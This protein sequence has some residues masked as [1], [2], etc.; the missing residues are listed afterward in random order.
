MNQRLVIPS[1][2]ERQRQRRLAY[3]F[4][5]GLRL[6][7]EIVARQ[8]DVEDGTDFRALLIEAYKKRKRHD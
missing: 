3:T 2:A 7:E 8:E 5:P 4:D 6:A 1:I